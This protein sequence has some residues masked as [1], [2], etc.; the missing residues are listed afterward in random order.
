MLETMK[1]TRLR[2]E[3]RIAGHLAPARLRHFEGLT[4]RQ[5]AA[6]RIGWC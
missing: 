4:I 1:E 5:E 2:Y 3:I 6:G